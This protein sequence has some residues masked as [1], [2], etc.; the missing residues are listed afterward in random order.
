MPFLS[1]SS[2]QAPILP[3][4]HGETP[5]DARA[6]VAADPIADLIIPAADG[7]V[8]RPGDAEFNTLLPFNLRTTVRPMVIAQCRTPHAVSLAVQWA[9]SHGVALCGHG[10]GHSYEGFSSCAGIMIDVRK[11][12]AITIDAASQ[13]ARIGA[14]SLLGTVAET[15]FTQH[16]ALPAG[17]C[18]PVGIAGLTQG[19]GHGFTSRKFGLTCDSLLAAHVVL[20]NGSEVNASA[21]ENPNLYWALRGGGGGNFGI[22]T[23]FTFKL[24]PVNRVIA[25]SIKWP[26]NY[27]T[28]SLKTWQ[29]FAQSAPDELSFVLNMTGGQGAISGIHCSGLYLPANA[30]GTPTVGDLQTLLAPLMAVGN[31]VLTTRQ[32]SYIEA[33]RYF[34]GD[35]DPNRI[36]FKAKSDYSL[37]AWSD[38]AVATFIAALKA[39]PYPIAAIF[40]AYGGAIGRVAAADTAFPHRGD[41][42]FCLQ[43]YLQWSSSASTNG[44]LA[45]IRALYAAMRPHLP[46]YS[47]VNYLDL[48][49]HDYAAAYYRDNLSR[50]RMVKQQYDPDNVFH[51]AQS[52]PLPV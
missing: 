31:P 44:R 42:R 47:Y 9:R 4:L 28:N 48:D 18:K 38:A 51:F 39:S 25:F 41:T 23:E 16:F 8:L 14:G 5:P 22:V 11:M 33:V 37:S 3:S 26:N 30:G 43:Y 27:P 10:G 34:A 7:Q 32:F 29:S 17:S 12:N 13:T 36:F 1:D 15:L 20:A 49:L 21:T 40:E 2:F 45:A 50:L 19:G 24:H 35:G 46:G 52:I 6:A